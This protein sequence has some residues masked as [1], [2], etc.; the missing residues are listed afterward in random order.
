VDTTVQSVPVK[1]SYRHVTKYT[2]EL[3]RAKVKGVFIF[4][5]TLSGLLALSLGSINWLP[6]GMMIL[7]VGLSPVYVIWFLIEII[8]Y[9]LK[10]KRDVWGD[11]S[12]C[13]KFA[14]TMEV[15]FL[16]VVILVLL[17]ADMLL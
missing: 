2:S 8:R 13:I 4:E 15:I 12:E 11:Y 10:A 16:T 6:I 3:L 7:V 17:V 5:L 9:K 14:T 1:S